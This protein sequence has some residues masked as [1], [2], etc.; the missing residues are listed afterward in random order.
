MKIE[1]P[2][3]DETQEFKSSLSQLDKG[4]DSLSAMLN[5]HRTATIY[6]GVANNGDILGLTNQFGEETIKNISSRINE[7]IKPSVIHEV[8]CLTYKDKTII[9]ISAS[10]NNRPY[11][12]RG[13]YYIRMGTEN[14]K[15]DP[16]ILSEIFYASQSMSIEKME[17]YNQDLT[18][19]QLK[20]MFVTRNM[21]VN[22]KNFNENMH[23]LV[24]NK[25]NYLANLL[26]DN[27]DI[28]IKV[29]RFEGL[30]KTKMLS[31]NEYGFQCLLNAM[32]L[33]RD[34]VASINETRVDIESSL[35]RKEMPLFDQHS[36]DEA[37]SNAILHNK[38][39]KN[40][41]PAIYIFSNR[42]EIISTGGLPF[43]YSKDNFFSGVSNPVNPSLQRI[44]L[45][46]GLVEQTGHGNLI[47]INR[48]G[49]E[50][51]YIDEN[52]IN[53]TIPFSFAPS[54]S[55]YNE[56]SLLPNQIKVFT[57][58]KSHP[59][60]SVKNLSVLLNL[61]TTQISKIISELKKLDKIERIGSNKNGYWKIKNDRVE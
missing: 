40:V 55:V 51:F 8:N 49:K 24:N 44:M 29:V 60:M 56:S 21:S 22:D 34:Y 58:I 3:E 16:D 41:P 52:Y 19:N 45:Q 31:R 37:W 46:L 5:K 26:A 13:N 33:A 27:N 30:D 61:G 23:F 53:V 12:S 6:F 9:K 57:A 25:F 15:I 4:I 20:M 42:I 28:S 18:F 2:F 17:S 11:S 39:V 35:E 59:T 50:A 38:W 43:D 14:K 32:K 1:K 54:I 47:I 48:Y 36:F 7:L 10:G